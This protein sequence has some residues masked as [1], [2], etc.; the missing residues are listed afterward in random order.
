MRRHGTLPRLGLLTLLA[1]ATGALLAGLLLPVVGGVGLAARSETNYFVNQ[2]TALCQPSLAQTSKILDADGN[3]IAHFYDQDRRIVPLS[4]VPQVMQNALISVEDVR[5][6]EDNGID[7]KGAVRALLANGSS[8]TVS[9]GGSTLTQ[10]YVKNV[11]LQCGDKT[12][13]S[14]TL[15]RKVREAA[16]SLNLSR[17]ESKSQILQGYLNIVDFGDGAYGVGAA[18]RHYFGERVQDLTL[19]Q[20][21]LLAGL[22]QAPSAYDPVYNPKDALARRN[23]VLDQLLKYH[24]ITQQQHD[25]AVGKPL[26]LHVHRLSNGCAASPYPWF[27]AYVQAVVTNEIGNKELLQGG[28]TIHTTLQPAVENAA[29]T[30][31]RQYVPPGNAAGVEGAEA[32]VQPGTGDVLAVADSAKYGN[33]AKKHESAINLAVDEQDG[34]GRYGRFEAGSTFKMFVLAAA[35]KQGIGLDTTISSPGTLTNFTGYHDCA[36]DTLTYSPS[37]SNAGGAGEAGNYNLITGT[38]FSVNTFYAQLEQRVGLCEVAKVASSMGVTQANGAPLEQIP[39]MVLGAQRYGLS[40]LDMAGAYATLAAHGKFCPPVAVTSIT[41]ASGAQVPLPVT[42]CVQVLDP[43]LA[44]TITSVLEG[45]LTQPG[46]TAANVGTPGRPAAAKTGTSDNDATSDFAGYVPQMAAFVSVGH[47]AQT[48]KTLDGVTLGSRTYGQVFGATIAGPI[49]KATFEQALQGVPVVALPTTISSV[50]LHGSQTPIP[51]VSG[52]S[53]GDAE[54]QLKAAN[55]N[56]VLAST[57]VDSLLP[58]GTVDSTSPPAGS[59]GS[60]GETVT[61]YISNG[62]PPSATPAPATT[63]AT[64]G[65]PGTPKATHA[66]KPPPS[67]PV[68]PPAKGHPHPHPPHP[69]HPHRHRHR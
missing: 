38:W 4:A 34:G 53:P 7:L 30:A 59:G 9:Q 15:S 31:L 56:P 55:F 51:D 39:S 10:Q 48:Q 52:L 17:T 62:S 18:A 46:A 60:S 28:L 36:G 2:S 37:I 67:T 3:V 65:T 63:S 35:L 58:A 13:N 27:C 14:D 29:E 69:P 42:G 40:S 19:A 23:V 41:N 64:P 26:G 50:F 25:V 32:I 22:V 16:I 57:T 68:P 12:A 8:G 21:A 49:W 66:P 20:S 43:A 45:V 1:V 44:D 33:D 5:F 24:F 54:A 11:L 6:Y 47:P 61:L